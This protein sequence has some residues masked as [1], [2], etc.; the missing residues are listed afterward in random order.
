MLAG[1]IVVEVVPMSDCSG[2]TEKVGDVTVSQV[3]TVLQKLQV[4]LRLMSEESC[5][6][7]PGLAVGC[8]LRLDDNTLSLLKDKIKSL[9]AIPIRAFAG[10]SLRSPGCC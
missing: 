2:I 10:E 1:Q 6:P 8:L 4:G 7:N 5:S 3:K 9:V